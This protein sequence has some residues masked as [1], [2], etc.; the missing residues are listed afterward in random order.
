MAP[1][2]SKIF[3]Y[4][5]SQFNPVEDLLNRIATDDAANQISCSWQFTAE[6]AQTDQIFLQYAKFKG[7]RSSVHQAISA[8]TTPG[9]IY[10]PM[11]NPNITVVG[12]TQ[13]STANTGGA[14]ANET[15]WSA[16]SGGFST[17][18]AVPPWQS[19]INLWLSIMDPPQVGT[20]PDVA[21]CATNVFVVCGG[22]WR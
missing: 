16:S 10:L 7:S 9:D 2:L 19:G 18:F 13:L 12:G 15:V 22:R 8:R 17:N 21:M 1:G 5:A 3:V 6:D 4:E 14:W 11:D 20:Y